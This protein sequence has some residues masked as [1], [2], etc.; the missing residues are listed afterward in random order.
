M[1]R[2]EESLQTAI[3]KYLRL[4]Y[5]GVIFHVDHGSAKR[6]SYAEQAMMKRQ[7]YKAGYP[8]FQILK[9]VGNWHGLLMELKKDYQT[10]FYKNGTLKPG[11]DDHFYIQQ[12]FMTELVNAGYCAQFVWSFDVAKALID[13]YLSGS[14]KSPYLPIRSK[15]SYLQKADRE[16]DIFFSQNM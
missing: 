12:D 5:P 1:I 2:K 10:L 16:A 14:L 8:D 3:V 7:Q 6:R 9:P 13:Q 4:Q 15:E 11:S